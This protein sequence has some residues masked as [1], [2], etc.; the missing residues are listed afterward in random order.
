MRASACLSSSWAIAS[1][2]G[3]HRAR[4]LGFDAGFVHVGGVIVADLLVFAG[5]AV[6]GGSAFDD[7]AAMPFG[8]DGDG[9]E[10]VEAGAIF[11]NLRALDPVAAGVV[12]EVV[13]RRHAAI[14]AGRIEAEIAELG[15][16]GRRRW[17][18]ARGRCRAITVAGG[19]GQQRGRH[20]SDQDGA[21]Q[22]SHAAQLV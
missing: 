3:L 2:S 7:V 15:L 14:H 13:A 1:S 10:T 5:D 9:N 19:G 17:V 11:R 8:L 20:S 18:R 21:M 16:A 12:E 6:V 22:R 4:A